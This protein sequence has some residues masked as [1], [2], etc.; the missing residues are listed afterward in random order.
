MGFWDNV[1]ENLKLV[2]IW[3]DDISFFN[4]QYLNELGIYLRE[5]ASEIVKNDEEE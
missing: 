3:E 1:L 5:K 2:R 4:V